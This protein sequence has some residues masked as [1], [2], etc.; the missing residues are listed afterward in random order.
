MSVYNRRGRA[1]SFVFIISLIPCG[2]LGREVVAVPTLPGSGNGG[3]EV[4]PWPGSP[5]WSM[6]ESRLEPR[7]VCSKP[8]H[9]PWPHVM[10]VS[11]FMKGSWTQVV[12]KGTLG[13][14]RASASGEKSHLPRA[15]HVSSAHSSKNVETVQRKVRQ[16]ELAK[17]RRVLRTPDL[18]PGDKA[19]GGGDINL[20][21]RFGVCTS[22]QG[23]HG[24]GDGPRRGCHVIGPHPQ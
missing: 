15:V 12:C 24:R 3:S 20:G 14:R 22:Q 16:Q 7:C 11:L 4:T 10:K 13:H 8:E 21:L 17:Q 9:C 19:P 23:L 18:C 1:G 2:K 6:A 5:G